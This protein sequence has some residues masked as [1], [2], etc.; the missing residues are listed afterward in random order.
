MGFLNKNLKKLSDENLMR[1]VI[2]QDANAFECIYHRYGTKLYNYFFRMLWKNKPK[3]E[4]FTQELF[5]KIVNKP[6]SYNPE[7]TFKTWFYS[8]A[9]NMCKNEYKKQQLRKNTSYEIN[10][11]T[12]KSNEPYAVLDRLDKTSFNEKL[13]KELNKLDEGLKSAFI[14]R[15]RE[16]MSL[17]EISQI[18]DCPL[19]T[20]KSRLFNSLKKIAPGLE[21]FKSLE[22]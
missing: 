14:L 11:E 8:I 7:K 19:G 10:E 21:E 17:K 13:D 2:K 4:D 6:D 16:E 15:Y 1:L 9:N 12:V 3:A 5:M 22:I 18:L 20:V